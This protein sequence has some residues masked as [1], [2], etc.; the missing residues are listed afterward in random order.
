MPTRINAASAISQPAAPKL[1]IK[2]LRSFSLLTAVLNLHLG[3][4]VLPDS[5]VRS[6]PILAVVEEDDH[7]IGVHLLANEELVVLEVADDLLSVCAGL[8]LEILD[9]GL[10]GALGLHGFLD[11]LHVTWFVVSV[12]YRSSVFLCPGNFHTFKICK[13][14]L[15]VELCLVQSEGVDNIDNGLRSV[16]DLFA[17]FFS[18]SVGANVDV[19][20][21]DGDS[22]AVGFVN[23]TVNLLEV[24]GVGDDLVVGEDVLWR[25]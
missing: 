19:V 2:L 1:S 5:D 15:L 11:F 18:R 14:T 8:G 9:G 7:S 25:G 22:R 21:A 17:S 13:I 12:R 16:L 23:N 6:D 3:E 24:V 20:G 10:V 4:T